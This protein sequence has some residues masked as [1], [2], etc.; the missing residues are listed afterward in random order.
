MGERFAD[1]EMQIMVGFQNDFN[2]FKT[3]KKGIEGRAS[4]KWVINC[5]TEK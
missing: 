2:L 3:L 1:D 4:L 5:S